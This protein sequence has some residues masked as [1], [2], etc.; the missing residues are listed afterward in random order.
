MQRQGYTAKNPEKPIIGSKSIKYILSPIVPKKGVGQKFRE[1]LGLADEGEFKRESYLD[2]LNRLR[3]D[4]P[5]QL[6]FRFQPIAVD[7]RGGVHIEVKAEPAV[8]HKHEQL[9]RQSDYNSQNVI[10][11]CKEEV[12][13][14][15]AELGWE[16]WREPHTTAETLRETLQ[17]DVRENLKSTKYGGQVMQLTDEGDDAFRYQL[18]H[19]AL[20]SY[21]HAI[22]WAIICY[23]EEEEADDL[24]MQEQEDGFGYYYGQ[25]IDKIGDKGIVSQKT[26]EDLERFNT[27]RRWMGHHKSGELTEANVATV[28][29]RLEILLEELFL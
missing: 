2:S 24:I 8:Y 22:E 9:S 16:L 14:I 20:S 3:D 26:S 15:A 1:K 29:Q 19:P 25:I 17:P 5:F 13:D 6:R 11:T 27:D 18:Y 21:I 4:V 12:R 28:K 23:L 7:D 10:R